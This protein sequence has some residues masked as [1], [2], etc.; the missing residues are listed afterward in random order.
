MTF[1]LTSCGP[2][3]STSALWKAH[4]AIKRAEDAKA[5]ETA[6]YE[7]TLAREYYYKAREEAGY[8]KYEVCEKLAEKAE[9]Y[10]K[11]AAGEPVDTPDPTEIDPDEEVP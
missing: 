5:D 9:E 8:S 6:P 3:K 11:R 2:A 4:Q 1:A 10:A 7:L